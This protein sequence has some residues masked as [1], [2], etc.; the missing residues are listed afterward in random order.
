MSRRN[1]HPHVP[2][3][4]YS[5]IKVKPYRNQTKHM[6]AKQN[7]AKFMNT[8]NGSEHLIAKI[9]ILKLSLEETK[10]GSDNL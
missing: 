9:R 7:Q 3:V 10:N 4:R 5:H 2:R 8:Q 6:R 1:T